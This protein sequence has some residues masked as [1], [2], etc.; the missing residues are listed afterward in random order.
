M[1]TTLHA[2]VFL[3]LWG[4]TLA[5]PGKTAFDAVTLR[6]R[7]G[8]VEDRLARL[9]SSRAMVPGKVVAPFVVVDRAGKPI[10]EVVAT[11]THRAFT[12]YDAAGRYVVIG[13][14]IKGG[15]FLKTQST[16]GSRVAAFGTYGSEGVITLRDG[17]GAASNRLTLALPGD[18]KPAMVLMNDAHTS[19]VA[20]TQG[21]SGGGL[22]QIDN[23]KGEPRIEAGVG[24]NDHGLV[25]AGPRFNCSG[26]MGLEVPD[27]LSGRD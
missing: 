18:S 10:F 1:R 2:A 23:A 24:S 11:S 13:S 3:A 17:D 7:L 25:H 4:M 16:N 21:Q 8:S 19:V 22:I 9:E 15:G 20:I 5:G 14:A 26:R 12:L 6:A 27:C